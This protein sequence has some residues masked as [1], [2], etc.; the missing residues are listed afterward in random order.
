[1]GVEPDILARMRKSI[2]IEI[3]EWC[4]LAVVVLF[5]SGAVAMRAEIISDEPE[6][7]AAPVLHIDE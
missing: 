1:M 2:L 5:V 7:P 4:T 6:D 3:I